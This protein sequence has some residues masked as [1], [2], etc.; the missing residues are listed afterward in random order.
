VSTSAPFALIPKTGAAKF[1]QPP[2]R[3]SSALALP[4]GGLRQWPAAVVG[5]D[6]NGRPYAYDH[7]NFLKSA[8]YSRLSQPAVQWRI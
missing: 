5:D 7:G 6:G 3:W 8:E 4:P 1:C 2:S